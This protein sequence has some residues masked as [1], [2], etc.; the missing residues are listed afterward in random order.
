MNAAR[1]SFRTYYKHVYS[2]KFILFYVNI[3]ASCA[4]VFRQ[5]V[6]ILNLQEILAL[7]KCIKTFT[8]KVVPNNYAPSLRLFLLE[9]MYFYNDSLYTVA[10]STFPLP[11]HSTYHQMAS[12]ARKNGATAP[13]STVSSCRN[14]RQYLR[15][16]TIPMS[17]PGRS[18]P[19]ELT[20]PRPESRQDN[21][22]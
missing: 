9:N 3:K 20:S 7:G 17:L 14:W 15:K 18:W 6:K 1:S 21:C 11:F 16:L 8:K 4:K 22:K 5:F 2:I 13:T 12:S 19:A 10:N